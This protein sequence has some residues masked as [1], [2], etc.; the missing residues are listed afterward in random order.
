MHRWAPAHSGV[1]LLL[2]GVLL[3]DYDDLCL[4]KVLDGEGFSE[5]SSMLSMRQWQHDRPL[6]TTPPGIPDHGH[7]GT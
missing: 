5:R 2:F 7:R 4:V 1:W 3:V 6:H